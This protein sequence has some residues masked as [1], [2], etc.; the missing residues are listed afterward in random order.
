MCIVGFAN[1]IYADILSL[2]LKD[3]LEHIGLSKVLLD[4][5]AVLFHFVQLLAQHIFMKNQPCLEAAIQ[6]WFEYINFHLST[7]F[8]RLKI[9]ADSFNINCSLGASC[10]TA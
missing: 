6:L 7:F 1:N 8:L 5:L 3:I 4:P 10:S 9:S 2:V